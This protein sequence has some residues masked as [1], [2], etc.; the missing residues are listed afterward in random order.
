M[1]DKTTAQAKPK[2]T[3]ADLLRLI[4][5]YRTENAMLAYELREAERV[6]EIECRRCGKIFRTHPDE[7]YCSRNCELGGIWPTT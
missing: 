1:T 7:D 3:R 4:D 5:D 2:L 6:A